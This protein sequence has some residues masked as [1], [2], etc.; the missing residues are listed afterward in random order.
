ME[1][2]GDGCRLWPEFLALR[3]IAVKHASRATCL[4]QVLL[5]C[6]LFPK[7]ASFT[8]TTLDLD[9][10]LNTLSNQP[11]QF[12]GGSREKSLV[13]MCCRIARTVPTH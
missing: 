5:R 4:G 10:G 8:E 13:L 2:H 12:E 7:Q 1:D 9:D 6:F 3:K 11:F